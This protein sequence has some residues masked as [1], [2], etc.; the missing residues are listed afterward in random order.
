VPLAVGIDI[1][2]TKLAAGLVDDEGS[3]RVR[4][5]RE[6]PAT[7]AGAITDLVV[8]VVT[9]LTSGGAQVPVGIGAAGMIDLRGT[10]RYAPNVDWADHPLRDEIAARVGEPVT[11]DNDANVA[12]W[13]EYCCGAG[14]E[15]QDSMLMLTLGTGVGGGLVQHG[16][17]VR[18]SNGLGAEFGHIIVAEGGPVCG[19]GNR[20]CLEALASGTA[21]GRVAAE[22]ARAGTIPPDSALADVPPGELV[23][24]RVTAAAKAGDA[25]ATGVLRR[26]GFWLGV[27][28]AGI[29]NAVDPEIVVLG[30]GAMAAG[31]LLLEPARASFAER[32]L[33]AEHRPPVPLVAATLSHEAGVVGAAL[34]A[35]DTLDG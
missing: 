29:V 28:I 4:I 16:R 1:G 34:C 30:G 25:F 22:E 3:V 14:R 18:G 33:G 2:G 12:A 23:G 15:A 35:L 26:C 6:T 17:L 5:R 7:D 8:D 20:G 13:A 32:L 21:I 27:G 31:E 11:V 10:V 19:C 9:D 24:Q